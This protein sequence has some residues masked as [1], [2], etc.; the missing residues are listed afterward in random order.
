MAR[1]M[2]PSKA[3][4]AT[5]D[6]DG[7]PWDGHLHA[8]VVLVNDQRFGPWFVALLEPADGEDRSDD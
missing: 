1:T 8:Y 3:T 4:T 5:F 2:G 6:P 7:L